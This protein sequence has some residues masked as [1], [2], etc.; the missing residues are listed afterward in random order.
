VDYV[1]ADSE[2]WLCPLAWISLRGKTQQTGYKET[3]KEN[4]IAEQEKLEVEWK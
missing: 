3:S 4:G 2:G 1:G